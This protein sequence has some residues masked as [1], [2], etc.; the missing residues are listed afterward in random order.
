MKNPIFDLENWGST[1]TP[2]NN[3]VVSTLRVSTTQ[4]D[5][6]LAEISDYVLFIREEIILP[7]QSARNA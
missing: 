7:F 4:K 3:V 1:Y 6:F 5:F 2:A